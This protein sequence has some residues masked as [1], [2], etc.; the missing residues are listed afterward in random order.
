MN[1]GCLFLQVDW[2]CSFQLFKQLRFI[3]LVL[4]YMW[5]FLAFN[6]AGL[7][8]KAYFTFLNFGFLKHSQHKT[9]WIIVINKIKKKKINIKQ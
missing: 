9:D 1:L 3:T 7:V 2:G 5:T 4:E 6:F 8:R